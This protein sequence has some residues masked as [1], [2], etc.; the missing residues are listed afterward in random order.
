MWTVTAFAAEQVSA[1]KQ[2]LARK[3]LEAK[4]IE[5]ELGTLRGQISEGLKLYRNQIEQVRYEQL[6]LSMQREFEGGK[7]F[8]EYSKAFIGDVIED[9]LRQTLAYFD[10]A[11]SKR[12]REL[13]ARM[14]EPGTAA[15]LEAYAIAIEKKPIDKNRKELIQELDRSLRASDLYVDITMNVTRGVLVGLLSIKGGDVNESKIKRQ[16]HEIRAKVRPK[17]EKTTLNSL[18]FTYRDA[19]V[20]EIK[21]YLSYLKSKAGKGVTG[22][23]FYALND[24]L[25]SAALKVGEEMSLLNP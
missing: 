11:S 10:T 18:L 22:S 5:R 17:I 25:E 19:A 15:A 14:L 3:V 23:S 1:V 20:D 8:A 2:E 12:L 7:L 9:D 6:E 16:L 24:A 4:K 21:D 13:E